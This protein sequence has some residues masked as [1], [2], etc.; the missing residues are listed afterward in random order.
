MKT[1]VF[2]TSM[3]N[4]NIYKLTLKSVAALIEN[5]C[6]EQTYDRYE[7]DMNWIHKRKHTCF[8][9]KSYPTVT[10]ILDLFV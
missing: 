7:R 5:V 8:R 3:L 6:V 9:S 1:N 2:S 10:L 4:N